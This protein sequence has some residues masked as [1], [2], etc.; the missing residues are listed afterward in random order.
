M[1]KSLM[2]YAKTTPETAPMV[3]MK[4]GAQIENGIFF[5]NMSEHNE[6]QNSLFSVIKEA[7]FWGCV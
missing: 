6:K 3:V 7:P 2:E 1:R 5:K 4:I